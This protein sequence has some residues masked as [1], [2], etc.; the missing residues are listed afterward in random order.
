[1][2]LMLTM[3]I[4]ALAMVAEMMWPRRT[5]GGRLAWRWS[6]NFSLAAISWSINAVVAS[7]V[8][9]LLSR[10]TELTHF[11]LLQR[12]GWGFWPS[13]ALVLVITQLMG[14]VT[15]VLFHNVSWLWPLHAIHHSDVDVDV[16]TSYRHHPLEALVFL[17]VIAVVVL[18][19]GMPL[20][21]A[22]AYQVFRIL[23]SAFSHTNVRLS[24]ALDRWLS[25]FIVTPDYH[26][27]HHSSDQNY[28][29]SNYGSL[30]PW[31]DYLFGTA[32]Y[33]NFSLHEEFELGLEQGRSDK[34]NRVDQL[35]LGLRQFTARASRDS[36]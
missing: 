30:V 15:H 34:A 28:T 25:K 19:L 22:L 17:P 21:V 31:F 14:Y 24:P 33:R 36:R 1:M 35:I 8:I 3:F 6:N 2:A 4:I 5:L 16:S 13:L 23:L 7:G 26:R 10:W 12:L 29:N 18:L 11:G 20:A 9:L 32:K 27:V